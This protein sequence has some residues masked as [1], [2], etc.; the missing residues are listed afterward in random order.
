MSRDVLAHGLFTGAAVVKKALLIFDS[1]EA[2]V[3]C[4]IDE[5]FGA[6]FKDVKL[7]T[8]DAW[9]RIREAVAAR[10]AKDREAAPELASGRD[11]A[12]REAERSRLLREASSVKRPRGDAA[13]KR[14][15]LVE[16]VGRLSGGGAFGAREASVLGR[17]QAA[18]VTCA[19][20]PAGAGGWVG[21]APSRCSARARRFARSST[22]SVLA[23]S[24]SLV[25]RK[26]G[27]SK[28]A[29]SVLRVW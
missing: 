3:Q 9:E 29:A 6:Q 5:A 24:L 12:D 27:P 8:S 19:P 16:R 18:V 13:A 10:A 28:P 15:R 11:G 7:K 20:R 21:S 25:P 22:P 4:A 23:V 2:A 17:L 1:A 26:Q 14:R